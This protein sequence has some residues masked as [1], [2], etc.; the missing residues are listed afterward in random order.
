MNR[1]K[2]YLD[3]FDWLAN[4]LNEHSR[5]TPGKGN[6]FIVVLET[7]QVF[8]TDLISAL[9]QSRLEKRLPLLKGC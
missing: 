8:P 3:G 2:I 6:H 1:K 9:V 7:A 4:L 5:M